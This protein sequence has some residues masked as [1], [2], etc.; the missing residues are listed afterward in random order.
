MVKEFYGYDEVHSFVMVMPK[1][2][3]IRFLCVER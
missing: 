2:Y 3:K 1:N